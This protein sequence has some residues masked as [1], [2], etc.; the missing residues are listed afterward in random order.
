MKLDGLLPRMAILSMIMAGGLEVITPVS[1]C[2]NLQYMKAYGIGR[3]VE[4]HDTKL[5]EEPSEKRKREFCLIVKFDWF[6]IYF[7][8]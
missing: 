2:Q 6:T 3:V 1:W 7:I 8:L 4:L 5:K